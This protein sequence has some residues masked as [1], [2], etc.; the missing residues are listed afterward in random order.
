MNTVEDRLRAALQ[1]KSDGLTPLNS[2]VPGASQPSPHN[3]V[4]WLPQ[5]RHDGHRRRTGTFVAAAIAAVVAIAIA[6]TVTGKNGNRV[7][8]ATHSRAEVPWSQVGADWT[9]VVAFDVSSPKRED[10]YLVSPAGLRYLICRLPAPL[11][12]LQSW[13]G[14]TEKAILT[15]EGVE[16][17]TNRV[18]IVDLRTGAQTATTLS[19][20]FSTVQFATPSLDSLLVTY[21][22]FMQT[23]STATGH[24]IVRYPTSEIYG[25][26]LSPDGSL[27]AAGG[28]AG[29]S[30]FDRVSG[31]R[32]HALTA[33]AGFGYCQVLRWEPAADEVLALCFPRN[34]K[35][36][37]ANFTFS[38][39]GSR[40][41]RPDE[42]PAGWHEVRLAAGNIAYQH[43]G[44]DS[45]EP[46][47]VAFARVATSGR[48]S[49]LAL[50]AE[51][52]HGAWQLT[53]VGTDVL[54]FEEHS[55]SI[56]DPDTVRLAAWN[57]TTGSVTILIAAG[58]GQPPNFVYSTWQ[59]YL[60]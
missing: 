23:V 44:L 56:T 5:P 16:H 35:T 40:P 19:T 50:P 48:L 3:D 36:K 7:A 59:Q 42:V 10:L 4:I 22:S 13:T 45:F 49:P 46:R 31:R 47:N 52:D 14:T 41:P 37:A 38:A 12:V 51:F 11:V 9:L 60:P 55:G 27:I 24:E 39:A 1:A 43:A 26:A 53:E 33:P 28:S 18:L 58:N 6:L 25:S 54:L 21:Q 34:S 57:P 17:D 2:L 29:L 8:P 15:A 20:K 32:I 30:V